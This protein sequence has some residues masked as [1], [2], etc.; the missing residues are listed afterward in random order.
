MGVFPGVCSPQH[1]VADPAQA[2][3]KSGETPEVSLM[4][5]Q[6]T[7]EFY[8]VPRLRAG[9]ATLHVDAGTVAE[10]LAA[11]GRAC[12]FLGDLVQPDGRLA[13]QY[14][15]TINGRG[16]VRELEQR[17]AA[18]DHLILLSADVGG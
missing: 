14:L 3:R 2:S 9:C 7:V 15:L 16:F 8:G 18:G 13:S 11:V 12:P 6:V 10:V 1:S 5:S 17:L 4:A